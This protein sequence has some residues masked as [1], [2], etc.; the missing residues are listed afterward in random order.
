M[1]PSLLRLY[2]MRRQLPPGRDEIPRLHPERTRRA[3]DVVE[4]GDHLH[5]VVEGAVVETVRR[6]FESLL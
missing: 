5:G 1:R 3:I 4:V 6:N 2:S